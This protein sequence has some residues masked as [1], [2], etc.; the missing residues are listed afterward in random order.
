LHKVSAEINRLRGKR[1]ITEAQ[2]A[3]LHAIVDGLLALLRDSR[4]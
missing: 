4:D 3:Q 2:A 1:L